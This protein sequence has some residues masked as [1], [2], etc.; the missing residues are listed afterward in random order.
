VNS[1]I[2]LLGKIDV[3]ELHA[4]NSPALEYVRVRVWIN[5]NEPLQYVKRASFK[6]REVA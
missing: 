2:G 3:V 5:A 6:L 1:I 4:K